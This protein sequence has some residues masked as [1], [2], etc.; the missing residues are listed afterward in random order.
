[1]RYW[2]WKFHNIE[3]VNLVIKASDKRQKFD[4]K[5][6]LLRTKIWWII[7]SGME[8]DI[9]MEYIII[10]E[11]KSYLDSR[12]IVDQYLINYTVAVNTY[13]KLRAV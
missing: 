9:G 11:Y 1:M 12:N 5:V 10:D 4:E 6:Y 2:E 7:W 8:V 13:P 3:N